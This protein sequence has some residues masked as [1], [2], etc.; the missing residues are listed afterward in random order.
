M[1][2]L[3]DVGALNFLQCSDTVGWVTGR[4][5]GRC[6]PPLTLKGSLEDP[7]QPGMNL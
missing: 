3:V 2:S 4:T 6:K 1:I 5:S 7:A